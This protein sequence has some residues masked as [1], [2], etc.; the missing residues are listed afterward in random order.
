MQPE[1]KTHP[2]RIAVINDDTTFL[3]LMR[4]LLREEA[5]YDVLICTQW[6]GAY[7]FVVQVHERNGRVAPADLQGT[8]PQVNV[9]VDT[10]RPE[11]VLTED[12]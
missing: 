1:G 10:V 8:R 4:D 12:R 7:G 5:G 9:C 11:V 2:A 6:D 3:G